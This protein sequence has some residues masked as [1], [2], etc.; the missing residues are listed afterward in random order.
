MAEN[1][2]KKRATEKK[3]KIPSIK[4]N[5]DEI[6]CVCYAWKGASDF[7]ISKNLCSTLTHTLL[8]IEQ[9]L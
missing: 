9:L 4:S 7:T 6:V 2:E 1:E 8:H 3:N 5:S